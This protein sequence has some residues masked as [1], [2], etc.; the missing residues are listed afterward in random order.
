MLNGHSSYDNPAVSLLLTMCRLCVRADSECCGD[1][2]F[3]SL[4]RFF[5][6]VVGSVLNAPKDFSCFIHFPFYNINKVP[7]L[8]SALGKFH[9][10][11][12]F[13]YDPM[14]CP[15]KVHF[16]GVISSMCPVLK[17]PVLGRPLFC[18]SVF[19]ARP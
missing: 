6:S 3:V 1:L 19:P 11:P 10:S 2:C 15:V 8:D 7:V 16:Q 12:A 4:K 13:K 5:R 17:G 9:I 18:I 14:C